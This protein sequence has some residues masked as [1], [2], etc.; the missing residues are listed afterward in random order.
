MRKLIDRLDQHLRQLAPHQRERDS[1]VLLR[2]AFDMLTAQIG[3]AAIGAAV[4]RAAGELPEG[5]D[6]H[7]EI[8]RDAGC[9]R[10]YLPDSD[11]SL[12]DFGGGDT[13]ADE[14]NSAVDCVTRQENAKQ[15]VMELEKA[16]VAESPIIP[17]PLNTR[18]CKHPEC[19]R[20]EGPRQMECRAMADNACG[21]NDK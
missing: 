12:A 6:L 20:F 13:F 18:E 2:E 5:Y 15:H 3:N 17:D 14:I 11:A 19:G 1:G 7:I 10:L 16:W 8:E 4:Q 21:R 9:V